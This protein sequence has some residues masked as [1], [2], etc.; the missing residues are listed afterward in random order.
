MLTTYCSIDCQFFPDAFLASAV[1][2]VLIYSSTH[3]LGPG[4]LETFVAACPGIASFS[5]IGDITRP[6]LLPL[7]GAMHIRR[8]SVD[9][10]MLF[11][12]AA[13][14]AGS[15]DL[16]HPLFAS[17][18]HLD[19]FDGMEMEDGTGPDW[20]KRLSTLP[21][22]THLG[23]ATPPTPVILQH[24]LEK[25]IRIRVLIVEFNVLEMKDAIA[26]AQ[27]I[28]FKDPRLVLAVYRNYYSD[29]ELGVR[30]GEDIWMRAEQFIAR[31]GRGE[32]EEVAEDCYLMQALPQVAEDEGDEEED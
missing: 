30:G 26:L 6:A 17:V 12:N 4:A 3:S 31:K 9:V 10:G 21:A 8:L 2:H 29:W 19:L 7:L 25:C 11:G 1:R 18:T 13:D 24:I 14:D 32:I 22:L 20:L 23:F 16:E 5:L 27:E 15:V 28:N